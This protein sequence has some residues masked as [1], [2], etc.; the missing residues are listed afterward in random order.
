MLY[1]YLLQANNSIYIFGG[2]SDDGLANNK[3]LRLNVQPK[4]GVYSLSVVDMLE[5]AP[6]SRFVGDRCQS[7]TVYSVFCSRV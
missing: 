7:I 3:L 4:D 2:H 6:E 5:K 1:D